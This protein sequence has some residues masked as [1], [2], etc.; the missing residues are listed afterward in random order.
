M[1]VPPVIN[2][3]TY[4]NIS[5]ELHLPYN[6]SLEN[7]TS[8]YVD[9]IISQANIWKAQGLDDSQIVDEFA[10]EGVTFNPKTYAWDL[11]HSPTSEEL[12][13]ITLPMNPLTLK[14]YNYSS[15]LNGKIAPQ[16][17]TGQAF[18]GL[19]TTYSTFCGFDYYMEPGDVT[20]TTSGTSSHYVTTHIGDSSSC[21]EVGVMRTG[22]AP[23]LKVYTYYSSPTYTDSVPHEYLIYP[24]TSDFHE[25]SIIYTGTHNSN[26]Y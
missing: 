3:P 9:P 14:P 25:Y 11:G 5:A 7:T 12:K 21:L 16:A 10:K 8:G 24:S 22:G 13:Y 19:W 23:Y 26:G 15:L 18:S 17:L 1:K 6:L 4:T 2:A 20:S